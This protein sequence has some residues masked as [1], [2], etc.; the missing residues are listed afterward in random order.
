LNDANA[1]N[2]RNID[3]TWRIDLESQQR[4]REKQAERAQ[5]QPQA[6]V[7]ERTNVSE[8]GVLLIGQLQPHSKTK[9]IKS[10]IAARRSVAPGPLSKLMCEAFTSNDLLVP[11]IRKQE[12]PLQAHRQPRE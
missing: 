2:H 10:I 9:N 5:S 8:D 4:L 6:S 11:F 1:K 7:P 3:T 12:S